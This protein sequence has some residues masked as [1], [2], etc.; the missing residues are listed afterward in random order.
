[1]NAA[2]INQVGY[3]SVAGS[4]VI[5]FESISGGVSPGTNYDAV[6]TLNGAVFGERFQGQTLGA[7]GDFDTLSGTP[8]SPLTAVAGA[9]NHNLVVLLDEVSGNN[10]QIL[11]GLGNCDVQA[12]PASDRIGEGSIAVRFPA[13]QSEFGLKVIGGDSSNGAIISFFRSNGE[14][15]D[16]IP[17]TSL[18]ALAEFGFRRDGDA[19]DIAGFSIYNDDPAGIGF[20]DLK[21]QPGDDGGQLAPE[22]SSLALLGL[23]LALL[24]R[25][26][27]QPRA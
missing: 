7:D 4:T 11:A 17:L 19:Q 8:S 27:L 20:D 18:A 9:A 13:L 25:R 15:I 26:R 23:G 10:T 22:P 3:G 12:C 1:V 2:P 5:D 24:A 6:L 14:V 16:T 21:F